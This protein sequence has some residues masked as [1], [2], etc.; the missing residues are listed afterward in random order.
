MHH[1]NVLIII[2]VND[3]Q[4]GVNVRKTN[5]DTVLNTGDYLDYCICKV[6]NMDKNYIEK[7]ALHSKNYKV[8]ASKIHPIVFSENLSVHPRTY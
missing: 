4:N 2:R 7:E 6:E 5:A 1:V 8:H 3:I